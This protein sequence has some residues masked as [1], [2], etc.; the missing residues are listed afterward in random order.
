MTL[1]CRIDF[2]QDGIS[3]NPEM[4]DSFNFTVDCNDLPTREYVLEVAKTAKPSGVYDSRPELADTVVDVLIVLYRCKRRE[5]YIFCAFF[6]DIISTF[7]IAYH[8]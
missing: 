1:N 5:F 7:S 2:F 3:H 6:I 4:L 8:T